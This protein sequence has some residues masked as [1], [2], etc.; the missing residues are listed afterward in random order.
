MLAHTWPPRRL[1]GLTFWALAPAIASELALSPFWLAH[2][3]RDHT[4]IPLTQLSITALALPTYLAFLGI[5]FVWRCPGAAIVGAFCILVFSVLIA[6]F[7]DYSVW[8][9]S[10]GRF[11][12]PDY[13]TVVIVRIA[14]EIALLIALVPP[15]LTLVVRYIGQHAHRNA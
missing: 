11:W 8:G 2:L 9:V 6:T 10:T 3:A 1:R 5:T 15:L 14:G 13:E 7:L 12:E 4:W